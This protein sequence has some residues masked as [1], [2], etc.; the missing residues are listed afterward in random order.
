MKEGAMSLESYLRTAPKAELHVHL[1][2]AIAPGTI[3][4]LSRRNNI[5]LTV[6]QQ[7]ELEHGVTYRDFSHFIELFMLATRSL[8]T[9]EDYE[10]IVYEFGAAMARQ[11]VRYAEVTFS[12]STHHMLGI[13]YEVYFGG[14]QRGRARARAEFGVEIA[15]IFDI[16]RNLNDA[17]RIHPLAEY[18][19][20]VAIE[21]KDDGVIAFGLGGAEAGA[22]PESFAPYFERAR[23]AG[24][25]SCPHAG[26][27]AGEKSIWGA[28][29]AL[30]AERLAHGV[31]AVEDAALVD[32]LV[33]HRIALDI[34]PTSNICLGIYPSYDAHPLPQLYKAGAVITVNSDDPPLFNTTL[35][36]E[37]ALLAT[38]FALD[39]AAIDEI[40]LNGVRHSFLPEQRRHDLEAQFRAELA[41]L[42][43]EH[44]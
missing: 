22:P 31:R 36:Q 41:A 35:N 18:V 4:E 26:E 40:L 7:E 11:N 2:G 25:H 21:G 20:S 30:G 39:V 12:P 44:L 27:L 33:E 43:K 14:L 3:L 1:E 29:T 10:L 24:L 34:A 6:K 15:W 42:K 13:P 5:P 17:T 38:H 28:I 19:T 37:V 16:V 8:K 23:A 9:R 32:Y